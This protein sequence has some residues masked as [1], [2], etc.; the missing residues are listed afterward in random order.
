MMDSLPGLLD[1]SARRPFSPRSSIC[2]PPASASSKPITPHG[3]TQCSP[4]CHRGH[5]GD[6]SLCRETSGAQGPWWADPIKRLLPSGE[7]LDCMPSCCLSHI[8][9]PRYGVACCLPSVAFHHWKGARPAAFHTFSGTSIMM[10][11]GWRMDSSA[12][13]GRVTKDPRGL[14]PRV[15]KFGVYGASTDEL[16]PLPH[17]AAGAVANLSPSATQF[18]FFSAGPTSCGPWPT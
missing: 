10:F 1:T 2:T 13:V 3:S 15:K 12:G 14:V 18:M 11:T 8:D 4:A 17:K 6:L 7:S 9:L 5:P 16:L